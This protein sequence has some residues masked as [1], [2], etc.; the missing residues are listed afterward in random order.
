MN[1][2][3][4]KHGLA[5]VWPA[6]VMMAAWLAGGAGAW[7]AEP[8][9]TPGTNSDASVVLDGNSVW[10]HFI[11]SRCAF[12]RTPDGKLEP[13]ELTPFVGSKG[14]GESSRRYA[15]SYTHL[16]LPTNREV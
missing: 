1:K 6:V 16:T 13:W 2:K 10:R 12:A 8:A 14:R 5:R 4:S 9:V 7:A 11:V 15:V 3:Q